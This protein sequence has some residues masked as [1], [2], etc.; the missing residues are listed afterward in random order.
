MTKTPHENEQKKREFFEYL[1]GGKGFSK[2]SVNK[3]AEAIGQWQIFSDDEDFATFNKSKATAY[4]DWLQSRVAR[5]EAGQLAPVTQDNY[6]RRTKRFFEWLSEQPGYRNK[7]PKSDVDFLRLSRGDARIA[8]SGT[9]KTMPTFEEFKQIVDGIEVNNEIDQ[10]DRALICFALITGCRISAIV[11]L[12]MKSFDKEKKLIDQNPGDGVLTKNSKRILTTFFPIRWDAPERYF[13]EWYEHLKSRGFG[14]ENPIF[15]ATLTGP[16]ANKNNYSKE[17]VGTE[18][19]SDA[20][21][22]RKIFEKRCVHAGVPYFHPHQF[23]HLVVSLM[24]KTR[25]TEEEKRAISLNLGHENVS[26]TFGSYGYGSMSDEDAVKLVQKL[27]DVQNDG[28]EGLMLSDEDKATLQRI[29]RRI[30]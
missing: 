15:P 6:L 4:V 3:F 17:S 8:R 22:A 20:G 11:S 26:T 24:S 13:M 2:S 25:L 29:M 23:R 16:A 21:G 28:G 14:P 9:T 7:I 10:R 27:K 5:T 19:W 30:M 18:F 1:K 12:R